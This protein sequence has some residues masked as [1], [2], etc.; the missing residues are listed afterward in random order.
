MKLQ[1]N[2]LEL[3]KP[4]PPIFIHDP[5]HTS[6]IDTVY[7]DMLDFL[8]TN[9]HAVGLAAPQVEL[10]LPII[11]ICE[12]GKKSK[13][14]FLINPEIEYY[15]DTITVENESCLSF[16][17]MTAIAVERSKQIIVRATEYKNGKFIQFR[18]KYT[19][20]TARIVQHEVDHLNGLEMF[21]RTTGV[22]VDKLPELYFEIYKKDDIIFI[23]KSPFK[24]LYT[25]DTLVLP[26]DLETGYTLVGIYK[27]ID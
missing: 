14:R 25:G 17:G 15:S 12:D 10:N 2:I 23:N 20:L 18:M 7:K 16:P 9:K 21:D 4:V 22:P 8:Y 19:G 26:S 13:A 5:L 24:H 11:I 6:F 27:Q 3:R 1:T